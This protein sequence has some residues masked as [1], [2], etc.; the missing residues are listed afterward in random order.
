MKR[1]KKKKNVTQGQAVDTCRDYIVRLIPRRFPGTELSYL[2]G[3]GGEDKARLMWPIC[4]RPQR[5][6]PGNHHIEFC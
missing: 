1:K 2:S 6:I 5:S 3:V 4:G